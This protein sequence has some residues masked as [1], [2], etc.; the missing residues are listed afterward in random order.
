MSEDDYIISSTAL[1]PRSN[2]NV[3]LTNAFLGHRLH[4]DTVFMNGLYN[5]TPHIARESDENLKKTS[6][7]ARVPCFMPYVDSDNVSMYTLNSKNATYTIDGENFRQIFYAH[8]VLNRVFITE[9]DVSDESVALVSHEGGPSED[10]DILSYKKE[11]LSDIEGGTLKEVIKFAG[12]TKETE[13][14]TSPKLTVYCISTSFNAILRKGKHIFISAFGFT[15]KEA[16]KFYNLA[17]TYSNKGTLFSSHV[18]SWDYV[19]N[20]VNIDVDNSDFAKTVKSALFFLLNA[21]PHFALENPELE[22]YPFDFYGISPGSLGNG[23]DDCWYWGHVFWDQDFWMLPGMVQL[24]PSLVRQSILYRIAMLP[25][26]RIKAKGYKYQGA[27][28]P[29]E[30]ARTGTDVCPGAIYARYENHV[31]GCVVFAIRQ[32][33]YIT[34][35]WNILLKDGAWDIIKES[36][37]FWV[38]RVEWDGE[39]YNINGVMDPDEYHS[40]VNNSCFT[41]SVARLNLLFS[42]EAAKKLGKPF[43]PKWVAVSQEKGGLKIPF[44]EKLRYHPEFVGYE[45]GTPI[46][47]ASV[48]LLGYPLGV[49]MD[50]D[51]R[52]NDIIEYEKCTTRGPGMTYSMYSIGMLELGLTDIAEELFKIQLKNVGKPFRI[53]NEYQGGGVS[54]FL[55]AVGG[56][57]QSLI[58]GYLG[59]RLLEDGFYISPTLLPDCSYAKYTGVF[60]CSQRFNVVVRKK[61]FEICRTSE[62]AYEMWYIEGE[63]NK[64]HL[65]TNKTLTLQF[66]KY[67]IHRG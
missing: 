43:D 51:V 5:G 56:F 37:D 25:G 13:T 21:F 33:V 59:V 19:W 8:S 36:A 64:L 11:T 62:S 53:W 31:T 9:V 60:Y 45:Q 55:T 7:R 12:Q 6:H 20:T 16:V 65:L 32:Y 15:Y 44:D 46:K 4:G 58:N 40:N 39:N 28:Y 34:G 52:R 2:A 24:F 49:K 67:W 48:V 23:G 57:L 1:P 54:N 29:W 3:I 17:A 27:M 63:S 61:G 38:S 14:E 41:N 35:S 26:A 22:N 47:Q 18:K 66:G 10:L 50:A 42:I 30:S